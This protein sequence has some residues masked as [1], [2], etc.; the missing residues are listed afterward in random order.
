MLVI[1]ATLPREM[2]INPS[3]GS[4]KPIRCRCGKTAAVAFVGARPGC[5]GRGQDRAAGGWR[6]IVIK[7]LRL[8][9]PGRA[10]CPTPAP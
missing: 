4:I 3:P 5:F 7:R 9:S 8:W 1:R 10:A 2:D 6:Q